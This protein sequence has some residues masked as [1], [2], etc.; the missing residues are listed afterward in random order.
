MVDTNDIPS[1]HNEASGFYRVMYVNFQKKLLWKVHL[2]CIKYYKYKH[3]FCVD[4][5]VLRKNMAEVKSFRYFKS[6]NFVKGKQF[7]MN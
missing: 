3:Q 4:I 2:I 1:P 7:K 6:A 5:T